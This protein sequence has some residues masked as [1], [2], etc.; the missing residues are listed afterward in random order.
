MEAIVLVVIAAGTALSYP[1]AVVGAPVTNVAVVVAAAAAAAAIGPISVDATTAAITVII[2]IVIGG[3]SPFCCTFDVS[4][5]SQPQNLRRYL[6][7]LD[8]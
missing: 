1:I 5:S 7:L 2:I 3:V 6:D 8:G 4:S